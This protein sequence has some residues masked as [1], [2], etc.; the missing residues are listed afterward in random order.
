MP[1]DISSTAAFSQTVGLIYDCALDPTRWPDAIREICNSTSCIAGVIHVNNITTGAARLEQHWNLS[2]EWLERMLEY[3]P[4]ITEIL[5]RMPD[6]FTRPLDVPFSVARDCPELVSSR[7]NT[8]WVRPQGVVDAIHLN[9]MRQRDRFGALALSRHKDAGIATDRELA[10]IQL[11]APHIRRAVVVGDV[12]DMR[13]VTI[14]TF[15][16]SLDL[17]ATAVVLVDDDARIAY[18]NRAARSMFAAGSP[19]LSERGELRANLPGTTTALKAA[20]AKCADYEA[21]IGAAGIG[22]PAPQADGELALIHV[23]PLASG[24]FRA[25]IAPRASAAL[26]ITS[27][28]DGVGVRAAPL[29]ELFN[30]SPAETRT[31]ECLIAGDT[32]AE[33][34]ATLDVSITTVRTHL[35]RI[36]D[37][38]GTARQADLIRL[39]TKLSPPIRPSRD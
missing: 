10:I 17:I 12:L 33:V 36:F 15:E 18:A 6:F 22:V 1:D 16:A 25:H 8:E 31:L 24:D 13:A 27:A 32:P 37:K 7:Y 39:A 9:V 19:V 35:A 14:G 21:G 11:L 3:T 2:P 38:T 34:A 30:L 4:E 20:I 5:C 28:V 23:L 29:A 26:F